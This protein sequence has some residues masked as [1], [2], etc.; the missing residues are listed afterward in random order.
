MWAVSSILTDKQMEGFEQAFGPNAATLNAAP[1]A[2]A[3]ENRIDP[4]QN[5]DFPGTD[6]AQFMGPQR[7]GVSDETVLLRKWPENGPPV[8]WSVSVGDGYA[9][10]AI[11]GD[12]VYLLDREEAEARDVFKCYDLKTG[13]ELWQYA[14]ETEGKIIYPGSRTVPTIENGLAYICGGFGHLHCIDLNTRKVVWGKDLWK[15]FKEGELPAWGVAQN[16]L[17]YQDLVI[18]A[19]Q[20]TTAGVVA[21][22]KRTG[23]IR[24]VSQPLG[25]YSYVNPS[26][27]KID[28]K[29]HLAMVAAASNWRGESANPYQGVVGIAPDSGEILWHYM[30][31]ECSLPIPP[32]VDAGNNRL[33]VGAG[34]RSG[35]SLFEVKKHENGFATEEI[36]KTMD[37]GTHIHPPIVYDDHFYAHCSDSRGRQ[38]GLSCMSIDGKIL[39]QSKKD[40]IFNKGGFIIADGLIISVDGKFGILYLTEANPEQFTILS[41]VRLLDKSRCWAPLALSRGKLIIR[42]TNQMKCL[43]VK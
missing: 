12:K 22:D 9:G 11:V 17:I 7:T 5:T 13:K 40:P 39:W 4:N 27:V 16:P 24:W 43:L 28:G 34:Y 1:L 8:L 3:V 37:F 6:W 42:D 21:F 33:Y 2:Q 36:Y 32:I 38:D 23:D 41:K 19:V 14:Y 10:P 30:N 18:V 35:C 31:W 20:T 26:M 29:D 15:D 25:D